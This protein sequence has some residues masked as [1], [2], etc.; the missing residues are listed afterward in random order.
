MRKLR[1]IVQT[2]PTFV[3]ACEDQYDRAK[4][5]TALGKISIK[6]EGSREPAKGGPTK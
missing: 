4:L 5:L 3:V 6:T 2:T 1:D